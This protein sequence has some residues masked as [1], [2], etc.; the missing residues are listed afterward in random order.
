MLEGI[1]LG[2]ESILGVGELC[3]GG[4]EAFRRVKDVARNLECRAQQLLCLKGVP[5]RCL[6][7]SW[8]SKPN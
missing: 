4:L 8:D 7:S 6:P 1:E 3:I 5:V 2:L